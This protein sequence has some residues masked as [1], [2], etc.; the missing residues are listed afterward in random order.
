MLRPSSVKLQMRDMRKFVTARL[1][2]HALGRRTADRAR[3]DRETRSEDHSDSIFEVLCRER[4]LGLV[5]LQGRAA[6]MVVPGTE[7][8]RTF[9]GEICVVGGGLKVLS[10]FPTLRTSIPFPFARSRNL[11]GP[12]ALSRLS[13]ARSTEVLFS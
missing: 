13:I 12:I 3:A 9:A 8:D 11:D 10:K 6:A 5:G 1:Q 7:L 4:N 2:K